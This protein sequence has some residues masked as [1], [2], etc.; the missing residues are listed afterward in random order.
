MHPAFTF[1]ST[2][3]AGI[4]VAKFEAS[5]LSSAVDV[6]PNVVSLRSMTLDAIFTACR[7][8]E[9]TYGARYGWET[10]GSGIDTH[11][12]KN[13]EW[14]AV[15]YLTQSTYGKNSEVWINPNSN[16]I[17]GQSGTSVS[18]T[19]STSTYPYNDATY[20]V[21]ASTTG[22]IY[23]IYDMSGGTIEY[24]ASYVNNGNPNLTTYCSSIINAASQYKDVYASGGDTQSGNY[25]ANSGKK[26]DAIYETSAA[27]AGATSWY[28]DHSYMPVSTVPV[29]L[30]GGD[31]YNTTTS[32]IFHF[33]RI[34]G[35]A[36]LGITFRPVV[37]VS[38]AL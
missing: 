2:E 34:S 25:E 28:G 5:G 9:T 18:Q 16:Y 35:E 19:Y 33:S 30:R 37:L 32:G 7:N 38:G 1:G 14:G 29:F 15:T 27:S 3:L 17:T 22:N 31:Y 21:N 10:S 4:W 12:I 26:G 11:L 23:G 36:N 6:K 24:T 13:I 20:G 8:M